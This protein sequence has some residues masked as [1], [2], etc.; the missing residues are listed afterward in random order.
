V[1]ARWLVVRVNHVNNKFWAFVHLQ[2]A[3]HRFTQM[4]AGT[5]SISFLMHVLWIYSVCGTWILRLENFSRNS[6]KIL[7]WTKRC[8]LA[9]RMNKRREKEATNL[10]LNEFVIFFFENFLIRN[11]YFKVKSTKWWF[12]SFMLRLLCNVGLEDEI[13]SN[14][15]FE[16]CCLNVTDFHLR[17]LR[18]FFWMGIS[19]I[20]RSDKH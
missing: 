12:I 15:R 19:S 6:F 10:V 7:V 2:I 20:C 18:M 17:W 16:M 14:M 9:M 5:G 11:S 1:S 8:L 4:I 13:M 3:I